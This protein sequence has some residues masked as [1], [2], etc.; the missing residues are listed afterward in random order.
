MPKTN[1]TASLDLNN[2]TVVAVPNAQV[3]SFLEIIKERKSQDAEWGYPQEHTPAE[4]GAILAEEAGE[5]VQALNNAQ[6]GSGDI[7]RAVDEAIQCAA[8]CIEIIQHIREG[9]IQ[10]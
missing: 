1:G 6:W 10:C 4:W 8:V 5:T 2:H 9:Y 3:E 7:E